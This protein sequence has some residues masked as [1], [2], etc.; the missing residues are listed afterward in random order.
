LK[1]LLKTTP[2]LKVADPDRDFTVYVD[3][4]KEGISGVLTQDGHVICYES[5]KL[6]EHERNYVTH[7]LELAAVIH[8]LNMWWHYIM[9]RKFL[10][11]TDNSGVK[12]LFSQPDINARK[13]RSLAV[14]RKFEFEVRHIKGKENKVADSLSRRVHGLSELN[15]SREESDLEQRIRSTSIHDENY[16]KIVAELQNTIVNSDK[17][18][19]TID[20]NGLLRFKDK[21]Y[22]PDSAELKIIVL[23]EVHK[24]LYSGHLG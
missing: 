19:L 3:A 7:D 4:I 21:L 2:I 11:L 9:G 12:Y 14:L 1:E 5:Q 15:I 6:K 13:E 17:P 18:D 20:K 16:T 10:L 22:I 23:D 24:K 8:A